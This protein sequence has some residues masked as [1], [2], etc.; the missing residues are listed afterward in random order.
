MVAKDNSKSSCTLAFF[1]S[2][3]EPATRVSQ[4]IDLT[5]VRDGREG[6][7]PIFV[8]LAFFCSKQEPAFRV[9][10]LVDLTEGRDGREGQQPILVYLSVLLFKTRTRLSSQPAD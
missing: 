8:Y 10:Q 6:Q 3:Q 5:E 9:S 4:L 7:Q 2:K 1:C